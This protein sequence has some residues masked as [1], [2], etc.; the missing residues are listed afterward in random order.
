[1]YTPPAFKVDDPDLIRKFI[2]EN[3]FGILVSSVDGNAIQD[4]HTPF[5]L[6]EDGNYLLGHL[7]RANDHWKA[8]KVNA[9]TK[10]IFHGPHCYISPTFYK[11]DINVPTWNYTA[12]SID[13]IIELID[14]IEEQ[15]TFMHSLV[16]ANESAFPEPWFLDEE[17]E[18]LMK[19]FSAV[20]FFKIRISNIEAK[21]KLNQNK[22]ANDQM[23][24]KERLSNSQSPF[25]QAVARLMDG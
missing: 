23:A 22:P 12:V 16:R 3:S 6:S 17:N 1:M 4:T 2:A 24:V 20:V 13:G 18:Q 15:K 7:A 9:H 14:D 25:D 8:W 11:S 19:L 21:F 5:L 10:V